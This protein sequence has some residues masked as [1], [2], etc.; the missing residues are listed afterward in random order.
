MNS[1]SGRNS[2]WPNSWIGTIGRWMSDEAISQNSMSFSDKLAR[3]RRSRPKGS[4][5]PST[6]PRSTFFRA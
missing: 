1:P 6:K 5:R 4:P 3:R 2:A